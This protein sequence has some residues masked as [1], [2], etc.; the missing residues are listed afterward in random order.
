MR[1]PENNQLFA[2]DVFTVNA[3]QCGVTD[4]RDVAIRHVHRAL[5]GFEEGASGKVRRVALAPD[6][7]AAYVDLRTV[8]E[9]WRDASTGAVVWR[10][11]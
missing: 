10:G 2:W 6:G 7:T 4:D 8:G 11:E 5:R 9:A 3:G 1:T